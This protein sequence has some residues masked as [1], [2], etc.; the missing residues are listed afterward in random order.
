MN[1]ES[2][3]SALEK[4]LLNYEP[5]ACGKQSCGTKHTSKTSME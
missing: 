1:T 2:F 3:I 4:A 5:Q